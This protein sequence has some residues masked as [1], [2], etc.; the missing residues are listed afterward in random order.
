MTPHAGDSGKGPGADPRRAIRTARGEAL[1]P[2]E[3]Y[4]ASQMSRLPTRL[5]LGRR[6]DGFAVW[7]AYAVV[8]AIWRCT[9]RRR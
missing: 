3:P 6:I 2:A 7:R 1:D 9:R 4:V 8:R 5:G